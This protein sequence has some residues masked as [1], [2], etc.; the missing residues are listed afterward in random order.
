M[1]A[2]AGPAASGERSGWT[3][4]WNLVML[5]IGLAALAWLLRETS[6]SE[7]RAVLVGVGAWAG[8]LLG[9]EL[10]S[11]CCDAAA[12]HSFMRPEARMVSYVRVLAAQASGRAINVLTPLGALGEATKVAML[13]KFA[14]R[15]R[16]V[17]SIV[18]LNVAILY[19][20]VAVILIGVP[21]TFLLVDVPRAIQVTSL[22]GLGVLVPMMVGVGVMVHRGAIGS[23]VGLLRSTRVI[24]ADRSRDWKRKIVEID[25]H[26]RELQ[27]HRSAGTRAGLVWLLVSRVLSWSAMVGLMAAVGV[28]LTPSLVIGVLSVGMLVSFVSSVIPLGMGLA[29]GGNYALYSFLGATGEQGMFVTMLARARTVAIAM[30]GLAA[31]AATSALTRWQLSRM[32][33][34]IDH[35]KDLHPGDP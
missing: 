35:L 34:R 28:D 6:W 10:A 16:V 8:L 14:P 12:L 33:T 1:S 18:L 5:V 24:S 30:L 29:D 20:N 11:M 31:M 27:S 25:K 13:V 7:L 19:L 2:P 4:V 26:I 23:A 21:I 15:A 9:L 17:S 32:R 3:T 22:V